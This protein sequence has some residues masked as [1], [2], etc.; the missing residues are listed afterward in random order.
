M[1]NYIDVNLLCFVVMSNFGQLNGQTFAK[2]SLKLCTLCVILAPIKL[3][4][5]DWLLHNIFGPIKWASC[6]VSIAQ[7]FLLQL[8]DNL[9]FLAQLCGH[10]WEIFFVQLFFIK[11]LII[12]VRLNLTIYIYCAIYLLIIPYIFSFHLFNSFYY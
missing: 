8:L 7:Y 1:L 6:I 3:T 4:F 9:D 12:F 5:F 11:T 10:Y 2:I